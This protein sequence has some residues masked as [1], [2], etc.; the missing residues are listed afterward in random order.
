MP[1]VVTGYSGLCLRWFTVDAY[2]LVY[3]FT[4]TVA[5][6]VTFDTVRCLPVWVTFIAG[7]APRGCCLLDWFPA[8]TVLLVG[9]LP[10]TVAVAGGYYTFTF[11]FSSLRCG[12]YTVTF[13]VVAGLVAVTVY[14]Y[15]IPGRMPVDL[16]AFV[17]WC[18]TRSVPARFAHCCSWFI[19]LVT[20]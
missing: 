11:T 19:R 5:H 3:T 18:R 1:T 8:H 7:S 20:G 14:R 13:L 12:Y 9:W 4:A 15:L 10:H 17:C 16:V 6:A 2:R